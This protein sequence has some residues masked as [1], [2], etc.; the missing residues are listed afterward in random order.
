M[1]ASN[2]YLQLGMIKLSLA[3]VVMFCSSSSLLFH[4]IKAFGGTIVH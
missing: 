2:Y 1:P 4:S 3:H